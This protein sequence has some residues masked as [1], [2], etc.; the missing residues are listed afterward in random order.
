M[1]AQHLRGTG[2]SGATRFLALPNSHDPRDVSFAFSASHGNIASIE[3]GARPELGRSS[4]NSRRCQQ[5]DSLPN[6][7]VGAGE[8]HRRHREAKFL[9][10]LGMR[11]EYESAIGWDSACCIL[12]GSEREFRD[13]EMGGNDE[14]GIWRYRSCAVILL[15]RICGRKR[16]SG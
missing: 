10:D 12:H 11:L 6:D 8:Q 1:P 16:A 14:K 15:T 3:L 9:G 4:P 7:L 13:F 5:T 2:R